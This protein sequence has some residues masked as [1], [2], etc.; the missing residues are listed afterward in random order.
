MG[1]VDE[2]L[3]RQGAVAQRLEQTPEEELPE[4]AQV[5]PGRRR[6]EKQENEAAGAE[7]ESADAEKAA[8]GDARETEEGGAE[9]ALRALSRLEA[10]RERAEGLRAARERSGQQLVAAQQTQGV[11]PSRSAYSR[12][13]GGMDAQTERTMRSGGM[14]GA[15]TQWSMQEISRFFE[16]DARRYGG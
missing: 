14:A 10:A 12:Y 1:Y 4:A 8:A 2:L 11:T 5:R 9:A 16:R 15:Q 6:A 13:D 7:A 3:R